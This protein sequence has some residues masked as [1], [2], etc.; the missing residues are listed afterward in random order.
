MQ[1][2]DQT[3]NLPNKVVPDLENYREMLE[4]IVTDTIQS[5]ERSCSTQVEKE[6][7]P[8]SFKCGGDPYHK[9]FWVY[10]KY[11]KYFPKRHKVLFNLYAFDNLRATSIEPPTLELVNCTFKYFVNQLD[12]LI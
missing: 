8:N 10:N 6:T 1:E 9:D 11:K 3:A 7:S 5:A 4:K 12:S 2:W